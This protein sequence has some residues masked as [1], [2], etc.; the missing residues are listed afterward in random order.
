VKHPNF[1]ETPAE[2][3]MRLVNTVIYY[4]GPGEEGPYFVFAAT[5]HKD[6]KFRIYMKRLGQKYLIEGLHSSHIPSNHIGRS[7]PSL[8]G[9]MDKFMT[10]YPSMNIVRKQMDSPHFNNFRPF[11]LGMMNQVSRDKDGRGVDCRC[12]YLERQPNRKT[13]Q[14][15]ITSM[16]YVSPVTAAMK[17]SPSQAGYAFDMWA[18]EFL[19]CVE[20]NYPN[21]DVCLSKLRDPKIDNEA[22]AFSRYFAFVRGPI[23]MIFLSYK[24]EIVGMLDNNNLSQ[25]TIGREHRYTRE[26]VSDL[27]IFEAVKGR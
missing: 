3:Q 17:R 23:D 16:V 25:V 15:L 1:F 12:L 18:P 19:D 4:H 7:D 8:A 26:A 24:G 21:P 14:G 22:V 11:P 6:G 9:A 5:D 27:R 2:A 20:G 10:Q 13:E